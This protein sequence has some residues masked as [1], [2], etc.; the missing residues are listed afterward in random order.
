M[1]D[2]VSGYITHIFGK[3]SSIQRKVIAVYLIV[4]VLPVFV[5]NGRKFQRT[6]CN[7]GIF[8]WHRGSTT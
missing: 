4:A 8:S 2:N 7:A 3:E 1:G 5:R 6:E